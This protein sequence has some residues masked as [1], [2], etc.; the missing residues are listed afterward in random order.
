MFFITLHGP[1]QTYVF[2]F[3]LKDNPFRCSK[4]VCWNT[5]SLCDG[6]SMDRLFAYNTHSKNTEISV[7]K[8][9]TLWFSS[10]YGTI[11]IRYL[12]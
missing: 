1:F 11:K 7:T 9:K 6:M 8:K 4:K 12:I 5:N 3:Q 2:R 10:Y